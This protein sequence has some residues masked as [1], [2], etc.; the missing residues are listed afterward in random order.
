M[1]NEIQVWDATT[2]QWKAVGTQAQVG[3]MRVRLHDLPRP[4]RTQ[5]FRILVQRVATHDGQARLLQIESWG[6]KAR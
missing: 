2:D 6:P 4:V 5:K 1:D 3:A